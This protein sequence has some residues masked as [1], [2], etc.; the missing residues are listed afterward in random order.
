ME[1]RKKVAIYLD[2][3]IRIPNF[4]K[5][6]ETFKAGLFSDAHIDLGEYEDDI[7]DKSDSVRLYWTKQM[8]DPK[9]EEFYLQARPPKTD[10]EIRLNGMA[11][12]FYNDEH[13]RHFVDEYSFNLYTDCLIP[14]AQDVDILNIAQSQLFDI[15]IVDRIYSK[16]KIN[17]TFWFLS[18]S[19][20]NPQCVIFLFNGQEINKDNYIAI[21]DP[22][23]NKEQKNEHGNTDFLE[24]FKK[25]EKEHGS[26]KEE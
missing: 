21:W 17:N 23:N 10:Y 2:Y 16:R 5:T 25:L 12:Y 3:S 18:K 9:A 6:Y 20:L 14:N 8:K 7:N 24:W 22:E 19:R 11:S 1:A 26:K 13:Y 15:T 4:I